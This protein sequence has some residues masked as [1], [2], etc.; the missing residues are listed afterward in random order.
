MNTSWQNDMHCHVQ[1]LNQ[2][3]MFKL[4]WQRRLIVSPMA[5][6]ALVGT[7]AFG[8]HATTGPGSVAADT[9]W[10]NG[11]VSGSLRFLSK[12]CLL[13]LQSPDQL[14]KLLWSI[15]VLQKRFSL[16][17]QSPVH[18]QQR[19]LRNPNAQGLTTCI[20]GCES[21]L[22]PRRLATGKRS[23][24]LKRNQKWKPGDH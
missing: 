10:P 8:T 1:P 3:G 20:Q 11:S 7:V 23:R 16:L 17:Q 12:L 21:L 6:A 5:V 19:L 18:F 22:R 9:A 15:T 2:L 24:W 13:F 14:K 4:S